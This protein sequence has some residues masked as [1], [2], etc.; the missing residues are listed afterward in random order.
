VGGLQADKFPA[1]RVRFYKSKV[2]LEINDSV[3]E[4]YDPDEKKK[5]AQTRF[6]RVQNEDCTASPTF[7]PSFCLSFCPCTALLCLLLAASLRG[8]VWCGAVVV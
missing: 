1:G 2:R 3:L 8:V 4:V 5:A 7:P 6:F